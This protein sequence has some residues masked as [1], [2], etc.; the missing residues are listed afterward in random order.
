LR[1]EKKGEKGSHEGNVYAKKTHAKLTLD[2]LGRGWRGRP[3]RV[4]GNRF[5]RKIQKKKK[6]GSGDLSPFTGIEI[7]SKRGKRGEI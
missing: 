4:S 7:T 3:V 1:K 5:S 6:N 2:N